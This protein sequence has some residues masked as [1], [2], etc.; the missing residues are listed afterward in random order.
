MFVEFPP[1]TEHGGQQELPPRADTT[2]SGRGLQR[3]GPTTGQPRAPNM[4]Y[5]AKK[6]K[7][8]RNM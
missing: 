4:R 5:L 6:V 8:R 7:K 2:A 3:H 1:T